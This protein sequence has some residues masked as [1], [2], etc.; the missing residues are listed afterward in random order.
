MIA[1]LIVVFLF[2]LLSL[3]KENRVSFFFSFLLVYLFLCYGYMCG[4]DW[5]IYEEE[6]YAHFKMRLVEPGYMMLSNFF[7]DLGVGFWPFHIIFKSFSFF[8]YYYIF[9]NRVSGQGLAFVWMLFLCSFGFYLFIDCP[10]R[11]LI[12]MGIAILAFKFLEQQKYILYYGFVILVC[13]F[14]L[15]GSILLVLPIMNFKKMS[16]KTL[17]LI[18]FTF[19]F[20]L[21]V[22]VDKLVL[23][24]ILAPF[25]YIY[26]RI[27]FYEDTSM[28]QGSVLSVGLVLRLI[29]LFFMLQY[30]NWIHRHY[31][32]SGFVFNMCYAYLLFSLLSYSI[33]ITFRMPFFLAPF[34][35]LMM[36][37]ILQ[38]FSF[39]N[40]CVFKV[41]Y[42]LVAFL[43]TI[44]TITER[45]YYVP[46]T[47]I[48]PYAIEGTE[49]DYDY[50]SNYNFKHSPYK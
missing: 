47:N 33:P 17:Y 31:D 4:S 41:F 43:I 9:R 37:F 6:Y 11:N 3:I 16:N 20:L 22:H 10:F 14:H 5:R 13:S 12:A 46:Y 32:S 42:L 45:P 7:A 23:K 38:R 50:R 24:A 39:L 21:L 25:P 30:R 29:C 49:L 35:L 27:F 28:F 34:Y 48:I 2:F 15:S 8:S 26:D 44:K 19:L 18:Y 1:Y 36:F 40:K